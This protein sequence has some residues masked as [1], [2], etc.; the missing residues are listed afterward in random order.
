MGVS[1]EDKMTFFLLKWIFNAIKREASIE[2]PKLKGRSFVTKADLL[3]QLGRNDELVRALG[4]RDQREI[5]AAVKS[6]LSAK[7]GC[8][9]WEEFL[10]FFFLRQSALQARD[11]DNW[12][13]AI[14]NA[15]AK[16]PV[17]E[18]A[19]AECQAKELERQTESPARQL[20]GFARQEDPDR[21][22]VKMTESLRV[23]EET[24]KNRALQE[25]EEEF[26]QLKK[27]TPAKAPK[28][29][30]AYDY[31]E[32]QLEG[33]G[34]KREKSKC[35]LLDSQVF[36]MQ[37]IF[38]ALDK[39]KDRILRRSEFILALRTDER[40]VDFI[41]VDAVKVPYSS[42]VLS[43]DQVLVEVER[44]E[45][46]EAA[47]TSKQQGQIN[48]KEFITWREFMGYFTDFREAEERN[49]RAREV[50]RTRQAL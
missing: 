49:R 42:K 1:S 7:D 6:A 9:L 45:L 35:L 14:G 33:L 4:Y 13:R 29:A 22:P 31:E 46:F 44:D 36:I 38:E 26:K 41:D 40:V 39:Y 5:A 21:R 43:L 28:P 24:R 48:H 23:L 11:G 12:W 8:L 47:Q 32:E 10:D 17:R 16:D 37:E 25:V 30:A 50:Q 18:Q 20:S 15:E 3:A 2:D 34:F 27:P 19:E